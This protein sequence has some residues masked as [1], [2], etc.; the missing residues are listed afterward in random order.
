MRANQKPVYITVDEAI[1]INRL[2]S[3]IT[4]GECFQNEPE[5]PAIRAIMDSTGGEEDLEPLRYRLNRAGFMPDDPMPNVIK[6]GAKRPK[7]K[8]KKATVLGIPNTPVIEHYSLELSMVGGYHEYTVRP[9]YSLGLSGPTLAK[10]LKTLGAKVR[11]SHLREFSGMTDGQEPVPEAQR[12]VTVAAFLD[13]SIMKR[14]STRS[15]AYYAN[16][17]EAD[18]GE[19]ISIGDACNGYRIELA[20]APSREE[21]VRRRSEAARLAGLEDDERHAAVAGSSL[22]AG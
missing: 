22:D 21:R 14:C 15:I 5:N 3:K 7:A 4:T 2:P 13:S 16:E 9:H 6:G 20:T 10:L 19:H 18:E 12:N 1:E 11:I 17:N 8:H